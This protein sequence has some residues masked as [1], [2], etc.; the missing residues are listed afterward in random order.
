MCPSD[1]GWEGDV[2]LLITSLP[3]NKDF[4]FFKDVLRVLENK[5][6]V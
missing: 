3:I 4:V 5:S 1:T 2:L 6:Y